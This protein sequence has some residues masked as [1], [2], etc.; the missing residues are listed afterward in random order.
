MLKKFI[1]SL[2]P[3]FFLLFGACNHYPATPKSEVVPE[4]KKL[5]TSQNGGT[6][7]NSDNSAKVEIPQGA[8]D[9]DTEISITQVTDLSKFNNIKNLA[10]P[11]WK[12]GPDGTVFKKEVLMTLKLNKAKPK[13][14][15]AIIATYRDGNWVYFGSDNSKA[16]D[17][18]MAQGV[19]DYQSQ[20]A[21]GDP[22]MAHVSHFSYFA[23]IFVNKEIEDDSDSI[24]NDNSTDVDN[25]IPDTD[26]GFQPY[27]KI[28]N[29]SQP[30][31]SQINN[32]DIENYRTSCFLHS[33]RII[34]LGKISEKDT[35][36]HT[37]LLSKLDQ[38]FLTNSSLEKVLGGSLTTPKILQNF[39]STDGDAFFILGGRMKDV[40]SFVASTD[41]Y[42]FFPGTNDQGQDDKDKDYVSML[43]SS[44]IPQQ[45]LNFGTAVLTKDLGFSSIPQLLI[46]G[47]SVNGKEINNC[48][49]S[50]TT[51]LWNE[52]KGTSAMI[53]NLP[54]ATKGITF[55]DYIDSSSKK[56][57]AF[58]GGSAVKDDKSNQM[59]L[60]FYYYNSKDKKW[61][62]IPE[63]KIQIGQDN[64]SFFPTVKWLDDKKTQ[65]FIINPLF[66]KDVFQKLDFFVFNRNSHE[67]T[68]L[69]IIIENQ[70][71]KIYQMLSSNTIYNGNYE[72]YVPNGLK[73]GTSSYTATLKVCLDNKSA[74][75]F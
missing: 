18:R 36:Y 38:T 13:G 5:I 54:F 71:Y 40:S 11:I 60:P 24:N 53:T 42:S 14:V 70:D 22:R 46:C 23:I 64:S 19:N 27:V 57:I 66:K 1:F 3:L 41:I 4:V 6:V 61:E 2:F 67:I 58:A 20:S 68:N 75:C 31:A 28:I 69:N 10:S 33:N 29:A 72:F 52:G 7:A 63:I 62:Q 49:Y 35:V 25:E 50:E 26:Q 55:F 73:F 30:F 16:G 34:C 48:Y 51:D 45:I 32:T 39:N 43:T 15:S 8:L 37:Q 12:F 65:L 56:H 47:G 17:P 74:D 9:K 21:A 44:H 59:I